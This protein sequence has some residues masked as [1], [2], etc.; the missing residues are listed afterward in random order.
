M[1]SVYA[2]RRFLL[3][4]A[5]TACIYGVSSPSVA[6]GETTTTTTIPETTTTIVE[7]TT[8]TST[9][10]SSLPSAVTTVP[11]GCALPPSAQAVFVGSVVAKD[12]STATFSVTQVRAG[13]L[14]GYIDSTNTVTVRY[15]GDVKYLDKGEK[16][17]VGVEQDQ[18]TLKLASTVRDSAELFGGAEVAGSNTKCPEFEAAA[19]TLHIDGTSINSGLFVKLFEQSWRI[20]AAIVI[21]PTLVVFGLVG[22]VWFRRGTRRNP[23]RRN[24]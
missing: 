18:V 14:E 21:P 5:A 16:Y 9:T 12:V 6:I 2:M 13:S 20:V 23:Q 3:A 7:L 4:C 17:I 24:S 8:T 11:E 1:T 19:R 10:T 15:G 22:L